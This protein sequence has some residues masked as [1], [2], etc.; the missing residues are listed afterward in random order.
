V[1][2]GQALLQDICADPDNDGL[3]L[4]YADWLDEHGQAE[5]AEFI[6]VQVEH[7]AR[8]RLQHPQHDGL[9]ARWKELLSQ[10]GKDWLGELPRLS[11]VN[12]LH[13]S[14]GFVAEAHVMRWK[15]FHRQAD[16]LFAAT[17][18]QFLSLLAG[19]TAQTC[20]YLVRCPYLARVRGL[21]LGDNVLGDAGVRTLAGCPHLANLQVLVVRGRLSFRL[22]PGALLPSFG[23]A[24]AYALAASPHLGR[25]T[26][27]DVSHNR[28]GERALEALRQRYGE[29]VVRA[30]G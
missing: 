28:L 29:Q 1:A 15:F 7:A 30:L 11:G 26:C 16:A 22:G 9:L 13:F 12:W 3:R 25:L 24:G 10:H 8:P 20:T 18:L 14:R 21:Y 19:V 4:I 27:L 6:R 17:P 2:E 5:R 23:D